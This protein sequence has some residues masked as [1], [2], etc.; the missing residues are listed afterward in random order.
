[1]IVFLYYVFCHPC[2]ADIPTPRPIYSEIELGDPR[3]PPHSP[4]PYLWVLP[5]GIIIV[6]IVIFLVMK[7]KSK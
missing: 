5:L 6:L 3:L 7:K 1:M 2:L 4:N